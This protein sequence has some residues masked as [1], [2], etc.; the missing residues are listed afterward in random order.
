MDRTERSYL[1]ELARSYLDIAHL[2]VMQERA[3]EWTRH[4][5]LQPGRPMIVMEMLTFEGDMLPPPR[6]QS[7]EGCFVEKVLQRAIVNHREIDDDKVV[8]PVFEVPSDISVRY[9]DLEHQREYGT[10]ASGRKTTGF[11]DVHPLEDLEEDLPSLRH[12]VF[13]YNEEKTNHLVQAAQDVL[14]DLMPVTVVNKS[15]EWHFTPS[16]RIIELMGMEALMY[17]MMDCPDAVKQLYDFVTDDLLMYLDWQ[18]QNGLLTPNS[19]NHYAG[20]GSYGFTRDLT[21]TPAVQRHMLWGNLNS[22]ETVCI[23]PQ[24]YHDFVFP[25]YERLAKHF[26]LVYYGCCEPVDPIWDDVRTLHG[27]RKVSISPWCNEEAMGER[28]RGS[29]VI[30]SRKPS[31]NFL[32]VG[33][34]LDEDAYAA[35]IRRTLECARGCQLEFIHRDIYTLDGNPGKIGR[36]VRILRREIDRFF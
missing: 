13:H 10:D 33:S 19:G 11:R 15:L 35:H 34:T 32:G 36:A 17:A 5:D 20:S 28:L 30:Y 29:S 24:M 1:R 23:S 16:Q 4:N 25:S 21:P 18:E 22:Q 7:P 26:G 6:C 2:P 9:F 14:G 3:E 31:P 12:Y 27:L 8:S